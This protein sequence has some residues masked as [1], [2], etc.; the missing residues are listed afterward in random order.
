MVQQLKIDP[1]KCIGCRSCEL[2]CALETDG[3]MASGR[4]RISVITFIES[5]VY[6]LP[7]HFPT[8]CR[9]CADAPCLTA[10]PVDAIARTDDGSQAIVIDNDLCI[11][12]EQCVGACPF[13]AMSFDRQK[14]LP[15]KCELCAGAPACVPVC[16]AEAIVFINQEYYYAKSRALQMQAFTF[17]SKPVINEK[18]EP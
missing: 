2:A 15:Y 10:C 11:H 7:Y 6:G 5:S 8:T 4:S 14:G 9:Q 3:A 13:G 1:D 18:K 12:C 16:P 17:L